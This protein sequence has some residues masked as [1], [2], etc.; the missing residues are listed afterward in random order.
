[1]SAQTELNS[2]MQ[3]TSNLCPTTTNNS[4]KQKDNESCNK[5]RL[6]KRPD[7][8]FLAQKPRNKSNERDLTLYDEIFHSQ[9]NDDSELLAAA[10]ID[11]HTS[12]PNH[13]RR[14]EFATSE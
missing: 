8:I 12:D 9:L 4:N 7:L 1:L 13:V 3:D 2:Q 5:T 10:G 11:I 6:A 14:V